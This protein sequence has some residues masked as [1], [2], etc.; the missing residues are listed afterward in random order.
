[1]HSIFPPDNNLPNM[2]SKP[3]TPLPERLVEVHAFE[4]DIKINSAEDAL[5]HDS[6]IEAKKYH[7]DQARYIQMRSIERLPEFFQEYPLLFVRSGTPASGTQMPNNS[8]KRAYNLLE[9]H[10]DYLYFGL[11]PEEW[12]DEFGE[13]PSVDDTTLGTT[14]QQHQLEFEDALSAGEFDEITEFKQIIDSDDLVVLEVA[15]SYLHELA[16]HTDLSRLEAQTKLFRNTGHTY[17][18]ITEY[19]DLPNREFTRIN[20]LLHNDYPNRLK[21]ILPYEAPQTQPYIHTVFD[22][23]LTE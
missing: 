19:I 4:K 23:E 22:L 15:R 7:S 17:N 12:R 21:D 18:N 6:S 2:M 13:A 8:E 16:L 11:T 20:Q 1:M 9:R 10:P 5:Y 14:Q 3:K